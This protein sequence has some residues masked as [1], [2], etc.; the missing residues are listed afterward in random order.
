MSPSNLEKTGPKFVPRKHFQLLNS[1]K[2]FPDE[3]PYLQDL[4][5]YPTDYHYL[6]RKPNYIFYRIEGNA[7]R[8]IRIL[9]EKQDFLRKREIMGYPHCSAL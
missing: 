3:G 5:E 6:L 2:C 8:I 9:N 4:I 7:V 1:W